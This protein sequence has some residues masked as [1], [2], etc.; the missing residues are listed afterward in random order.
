MN[1]KS[2]FAWKRK[3]VFFRWFRIDAKQQNSEAKTKRKYHGKYE[4]NQGEG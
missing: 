1:R 2:G 3:K 4:V